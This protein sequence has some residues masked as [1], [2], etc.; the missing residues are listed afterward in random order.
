[1][2][3]EGKRYSIEI[4]DNPLFIDH[5]LIDNR[6]GTIRQTSTYCHVQIS[7]NEHR[8]VRGNGVEQRLA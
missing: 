1:M 6:D 2:F 8:D 4:Q 7:S 3:P 5:F